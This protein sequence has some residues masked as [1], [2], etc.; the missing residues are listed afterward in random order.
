LYYETNYGS[1]KPAAGNRILE[2]VRQK[3]Q[4][5]RLER[6]VAA[7]GALQKSPFGTGFLPPEAGATK[8][9]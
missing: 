8:S 7:N 4:L 9:P 2:T 3:S 1:G 6:S 5:K